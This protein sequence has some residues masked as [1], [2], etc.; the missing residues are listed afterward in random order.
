MRR[1]TFKIRTYKD[2]TVLT[3]DEVRDGRNYKT[4][5]VVESDDEMYLNIA[6][7]MWWNYILYGVIP[8]TNA[9]VVK[10]TKNS[11]TIEIDEKQVGA[12]L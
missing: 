4:R 1:A 11:V 10:A 5:V 7:A 8:D 3:I 12:T 2:K 9:R 6:K